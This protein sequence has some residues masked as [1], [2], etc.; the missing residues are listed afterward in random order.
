MGVQIKKA[1]KAGAESAPE[2]QYQHQAE[3]TVQTSVSHAGK[4]TVEEEHTEKVGPALNYE[5]PVAEVMFKAGIT[6]NMGDYNSARIDVALTL[7]CEPTAPDL[8]VAF[9][10]SRS[11][12]DE[13]LQDLLS[14]M[15]GAG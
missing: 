13:R 4:E 14:E 11:W 12:V 7:P 9:A 6:R 8:D 5:G 1:K 2:S 10:Y 3:A 15:D